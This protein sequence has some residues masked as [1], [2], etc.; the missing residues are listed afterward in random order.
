MIDGCDTVVPFY[1]L[2]SDASNRG[3]KKLFPVAFR[4]R[5]PK[6]GVE[7]KVLD[8]YDDPV[9][10]CAGI[11]NQIKAR[12]TENSLSMEN[13]SSYLADNASVHFGKHNSVFQKLQQLN[14][15]TQRANCPAHILH[16]CA[17]QAAD[18]LDVDMESLVVKIF[19]HFSS[20]AKRITELK[21][22]FQFLGED[23]EDMLRHVG[24]R[25]LTLYPATERLSKCWP[26]IKSYFLSLG[27]D[28][29][30]RRIWK[31]LKG[32]GEGETKG[33]ESSIIPAYCEF[34]KM[35]YC[36]FNAQ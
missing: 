29:C 16:N 36:L 10:T 18:K 26:A 4:Y 15:A 1:S 6:N 5:T 17:K 14:P 2:A 31:Y 3:N 7:N 33:E 19:N 23:Y 21:N 8:F 34:I 20:A 30:P 27:A 13:I 25:W 11:A 9:E 32:C 35:R 12:L 28:E 24:T 22:V